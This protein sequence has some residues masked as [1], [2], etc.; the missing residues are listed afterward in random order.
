MQPIKNQFKDLT[1]EELIRQ[2]QKTNE[3]QYFDVLYYRY[4]TAM[5][6]VSKKYTKNLSASK[7]ITAEIFLQLLDNPP[8]QEIL[9]FKNW[10]YSIAVYASFK[11]IKKSKIIVNLYDTEKKSEIFMELLN[12]DALFNKQHDLAHLIYLALE[13]LPKE[14]QQCISLFYFKKL[15][16]NQIIAETSF[17]R[18]N[19]RSA[20]QNGRRNI[21]NYLIKKHNF[22][23]EN[24]F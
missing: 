12:F 17:T 15:S 7:D 4:Y 18:N 24:F 2:L 11:Y 6:L 3:Y 16:Y 9:N 20:I 23:N 14:Q 8:K 22:N 19:V 5:I 13:T 21:K 10:I 1:D